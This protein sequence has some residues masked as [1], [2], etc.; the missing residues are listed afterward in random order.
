VLYLPWLFS[1]IFN[2]RVIKTIIDSPQS[3]AWRE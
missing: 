1:T 2:T 3:Q